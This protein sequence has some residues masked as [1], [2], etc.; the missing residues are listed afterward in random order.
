MKH[1]TKMAVIAA[2]ALTSGISGSPNRLY[3]KPDQPRDRTHDAERIAKAH[4]KRERRAAKALRS[5]P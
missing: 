5:K 3:T 2:A 1:S 4:A